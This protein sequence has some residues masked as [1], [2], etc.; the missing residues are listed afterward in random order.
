[1]DNPQFYGLFKQATIGD[2]NIDKPG[3]FDFVARAKYDA[4]QGF[5]G[6]GF[7]EAR[8]M[9]IDGVEEL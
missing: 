3:L 4:W 7:R 6:L 9:Y 8:N 1:E 5:K 2:C